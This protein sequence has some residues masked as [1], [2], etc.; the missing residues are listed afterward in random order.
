MINYFEINY[1]WHQENQS[2]YFTM[3]TNNM[4]LLWL[5]IK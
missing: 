5:L 1:F 2:Q 3:L 4:C